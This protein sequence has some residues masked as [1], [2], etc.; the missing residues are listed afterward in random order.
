VPPTGQAWTTRWVGVRIGLLAALLAAGFGAVAVR[1]FQLQVIRRD[2]EADGYLTELK[3]RPRRGV[4]TDRNGNPL[5]ASADVQSAYAD[6]E[7][8]FGGG[9]KK[10]LLDQDGKL[11]AQ[12]RRLGETRL[13]QAARM[14]GQDPEA[15]LARAG[16]G[17]RFLWLSRRL[18]PD[19]EKALRDWLAREKV[20]GIALVA[21]QRRYYPKLEVASS[22]LGLVGD[23]G[24]GIEGIE[25]SQ[26]DRLQGFSAEVRAIRDGKGH[27]L[28]PDAPVTA[29]ERQ[30]DTIVLTLDQGIQATAERALSRAVVAS[31]AVSG[32]AVVL[33]P[34]TGEVLALA[35]WPVPTPPS[36]SAT[37]RSPTPSSRGPP[38]R[39]S[40]SPRRWRPGP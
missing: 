39:P 10:E 5:A 6:P 38:S 31:R 3:L 2:L 1:A 36:S 4:I 34:R 19:R 24:M 18:L 26:E 22:V 27:F 23:D 11:R 12:Q 35:S 30:G 37:G 9:L 13:R 21:E 29:R 33:D 32:M 8:L 17:G 28:V 25:L 40:P 20:K 7:L 14:L 15:L 16:R